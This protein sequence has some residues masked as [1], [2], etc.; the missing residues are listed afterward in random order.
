MVCTTFLV[1]QT[2][3]EEILLDQSCQSI[4]FYINLPLI[5]WPVL[6]KQTE[7]NQDISQ[8]TNI[9]FCWYTITFPWL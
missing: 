1:C 2:L 6:M 7:I 9:Q 4:S 3:T 8:N 5:K